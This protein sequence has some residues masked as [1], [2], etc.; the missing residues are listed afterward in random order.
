MAQA[1]IDIVRA[2]VADPTKQI[3]TLTAGLLRSSPRDSTREQI[4]I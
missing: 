1:L 4:S 2:C 3:S